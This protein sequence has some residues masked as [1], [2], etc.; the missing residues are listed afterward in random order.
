MT[1]CPV[2]WY[3]SWPTQVQMLLQNLLAELRHL[4]LTVFFLLTQLA[5]PCQPPLL[6]IGPLSDH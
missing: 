3:V 5:L 2:I 6:F 1:F 4:V